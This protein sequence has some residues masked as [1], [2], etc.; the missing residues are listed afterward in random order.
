MSSDDSHAAHDTRA[1]GVDGE[2]LRVALFSGN[3][4][5]VMDGPVR[6]LNKLVAHL[7]RRR[8]DVL[9]FAPTS[10]ISYLDHAGELIS[11]PSTA[12]P[13]RPE[14][15]IGLGLHGEAKKR[16]Q[17]FA[18]NLIHIS[19][20]DLGGLGALNF[21]RKNNIPAVA[22][23]HTR[24]DTYPRYYGMAWAE[25]LLTK[26]MKY[27]YNRCVHVYPP[28]QSMADELLAE[29]IGKEM[30]LW[31]RGVDSEQFN[32]AKRDLAWRQSVNIADDDI[33]VLFVGRLVLEKGIDH[34]ASA[35][36]AAR[37]HVPALRPLVVGA[38]PELEHFRSVSPDA[39]F[40]G[41]QEGD[42]LARAYASGD[43]FFNPSITET[44]GQVTLEAM[45]SGLPSL[46]ANAAGSLSLVDHDTTGFIAEARVDAFT[47]K[48]IELAR[49]R[50]LRVRMGAAARAKALTFSWETIL[51]D[52]ITNYR[53]AIAQYNGA[54]RNETQRQ[55]YSAAA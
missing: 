40:I 12:A 16:L 27:F 44:F 37:E 31:T 7:E 42:E 14:Y 47:E 51:D 45:A 29:G 4:N 11:L 26:Y 20:P 13:R 43:V 2:T 36:T 17:A 50:E 10:K 1:P 35:V 18:P 54:G 22:S 32:P 48:L 19:A 46:C 34:F 38:G 39:V 23:F 15:R 28:S 53:E 41:H 8:H 6:A 5:Y 49:S 33:A 9:V 21:A 24:F 55:T 52:L 30:R 3:Y 25:G